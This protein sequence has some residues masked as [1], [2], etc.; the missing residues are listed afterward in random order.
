MFDVGITFSPGQ[1]A[2]LEGVIDLLDVVEIEPQ[3]YCL[4]APSGEEWIADDVLEALAELPR[5]KLLHS[6]G[7][8]VANERFDP[9]ALALLRR[10]GGR[11]GCEYFS[12]HLALN[13]V[14]VD[15]AGEVFTGFFLPPE[16]SLREAERIG[17]NARELA[18]A[19]GLPIALETAVNYLEDASGELSDGELVARTVDAAGAGILLDLHNIWANER[20][21]RQAVDDFIDALPLD[22]VWEIHLADGCA[23]DGFWLDAHSGLPQPRLL[24][25]L[26]DLLPRLP[27]L[28]S[29]VFELLPEH[30]AA[31]DMDAARAFLKE[32]RRLRAAHGR[33][34]SLVVPRPRPTGAVD[35]SAGAGTRAQAQAIL[36]LDG[37]DGG[38][39]AGD[40][41]VALY[42]RL[43][44]DIRF[45]QIV[46]ALP[47]TTREACLAHGPDAFEA[48]MRRFC[49][50]SSPSPFPSGE[51]LGFV[52]FLGSIDT[53][54][55]AARSAAAAERAA[56]LATLEA[57]E[58]TA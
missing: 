51:A 4:R 3:T 7:V 56:I 10:V 18:R 54:A 31:I 36:G 11:L 30:S 2:L 33:R 35:G 55:A 45:S 14:D 22:R 24:E 37:R 39:L 44:A 21:G 41:G 23:L 9:A 26:A 32:L 52:D 29:V 6:V 48:W 40:R 53:L 15:G 13:R 28:R 1:G 42:R 47:R 16:A 46:T 43:I 50:A 49:G 38:P 20:N 5:P 12:E 58:R 27:N 34:P 8:P 25:L 19:V 57:P 17:R